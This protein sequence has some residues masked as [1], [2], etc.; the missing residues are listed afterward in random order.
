MVPNWKENIGIFPA[1]AKAKKAAVLN[2][3]NR[4]I[5]FQGGGITGVLGETGY[6]KAV[7]HQQ[8]WE[9]LKF[10]DET[11]ITQANREL[12]PGTE[13]AYS[14]SDFGYIYHINAPSRR[15]D[16]LLLKEGTKA[17][18]QHANQKRLQCIVLTAAG[19]A[20]FG[21]RS[22][23]LGLIKGI[24]AFCHQYPESDLRIVL[25]NWET[26]IVTH[27]KALKNH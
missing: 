14:K 23:Y 3:S 13:A 18:L 10:L 2:A 20:T 27:V 5:T 16:S 21:N 11:P 19:T 7:R 1:V 4:T 26:D 15:V 24:E 9:A 25:L 8:D 12:A 6:E 17:I 22:A